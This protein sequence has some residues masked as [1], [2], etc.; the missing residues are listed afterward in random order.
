METGKCPR[1]GTVVE[2][3]GGKVSPG[4]KGKVPRLEVPQTSIHMAIVKQY[5]QKSTTQATLKWSAPVHVV[6]WLP[7]FITDFT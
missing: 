6:E 4:N 3:D 7:G 1:Q 5:S 2:D